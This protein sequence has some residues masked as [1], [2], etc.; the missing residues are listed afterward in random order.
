MFK[1]LLSTFIVIVSIGLCLP[2]GILA[3]NAGQEQNVDPNEYYKAEVVKVL[4]EDKS[5]NHYDALV[6]VK[7]LEGP[8]KNEEINI[9]F[10]KLAGISEAEKLSKGEKII[11]IKTESSEG[12]E[13]FLVDRY[14]MDAVII[15]LIVV[16]LVAILIARFK[17]VNAIIGLGLSILILV[18]YA[19]P[20][21]TSGQNPIVVGILGSGLIIVTSMFL[22]HGFNRRTSVSVL[23]TFITIT[24][25]IIISILTVNFT[26]LFGLGT[27]DAYFLQN[28]QFGQIDVRGLLLAGIIVGTLGILDDITVA[29]VAIVE[30]I[31]DV[32]KSIP[33]W[34]LFKRGL[35]VGKEHIASL[36]NTLALAYVGASFPLLL[37][38]SISQG[39]PLWVIA[40]SEM[41]IEEVARTLLGSLALI[42]AVPIATFLGVY[43]I[44]YPVSWLQKL[45]ESKEHGHSHGH[46]HIH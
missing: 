10:Q 28:S 3:Q 4:T 1:K 11:V 8:N 14:R 25:S 6:R 19:I 5:E 27:E 21:L 46:T 16:V 20:A 13:Y 40:N 44:K 34:D 32:D 45:P 26:K 37:S 43:F 23:A 17:A 15:L 30:E 24:I 36:V 18:K 22:A 2:I 38:F 42:L 31:N 7:L 33:F 9:K 41:I 12:A 29:Q 39:Q 35:N